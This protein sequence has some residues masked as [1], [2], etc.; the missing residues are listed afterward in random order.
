MIDLIFMISCILR[1]LQAII[2]QSNPFWN[3]E[4][5]KLIP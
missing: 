1:K 3:F 2:V 4:K 5:Q